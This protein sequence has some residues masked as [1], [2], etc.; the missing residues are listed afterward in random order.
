MFPKTY[1]ATGFSFS[2]RS[3][4]RKKVKEIISWI[5]IIC[6]YYNQNENSLTSYVTS[7]TVEIFW[8]ILFFLKWQKVH[9]LTSL[10]ALALF[11]INMR[12]EKLECGK[13][14]WPT[15]SCNDGTTNCFKLRG[16]LRAPTEG[17]EIADK[18]TRNISPW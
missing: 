4:L 14:A 15:S 5:K 17:I 16:Q 10:F 12:K 8:G 1:C 18:Y 9:L 3:I 7:E 2:S 6:F 11:G 13:K